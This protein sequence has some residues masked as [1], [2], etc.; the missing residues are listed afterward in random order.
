M[1][2]M[3][4][5]FAGDEKQEIQAREA[6]QRQKSRIVIF[7]NEFTVAK[8]LVHVVG[9]KKTLAA[10]SRGKGASPGGPAQRRRPREACAWSTKA[11]GS[12]LGLSPHAASRACVCISTFCSKAFALVEPNQ[13]SPSRR[14]QSICFAL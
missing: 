6:G 8:A 14:R 11:D 2:H 3:A 9:T 12:G 13:A 10:Y 4:S 7:A 1:T 5:G